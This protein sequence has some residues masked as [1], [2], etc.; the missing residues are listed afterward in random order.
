MEQQNV[1]VATE[2]DRAMSSA[3]VAK[4]E[5]NNDAYRNHMNTA[6]YLCAHARPVVPEPVVPE[7][8]RRMNACAGQPCSKWFPCDGGCG[9]Y[10]RYSPVLDNN[11]RKQLEEDLNMFY[12]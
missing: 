6:F 5:G 8:A 7:V 11:L 4:R 10:P 9:E 3:A 12:F 2:F 1:R